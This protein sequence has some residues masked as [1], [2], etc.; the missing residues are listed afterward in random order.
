[1]TRRHVVL[2]QDNRQERASKVERPE[3]TDVGDPDDDRDHGADRGQEETLEVLDV[4]ESL[5]DDPLCVGGRGKW[6]RGGRIRDDGLLLVEL[7]KALNGQRGW[8]RAVELRDA[9]KH[10]DRF[11]LATLAEQVLGRLLEAED[12]ETYK[13]DREGDGTQNDHQVAPAH[14]ASS[15]A[16]RLASGNCGTGLEVDVTSVFGNG[17]VGNGAADD[18]TDW[19]PHGQESEQE[20][21][22]LRQKF[23]GDGCVNWDLS[24]ETKLG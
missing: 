20:S 23:E 16:A 10:I 19:L 21:A 24:A 2:L 1:M 4:V 13:E 6:G 14:V 8:C 17:A 15:R 3:V 18:D 22:V 9:V 11:L 12:D 5:A 7:S